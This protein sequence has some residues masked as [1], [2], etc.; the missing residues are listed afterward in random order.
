[1]DLTSIKANWKTT[2]LGIF[3]IMGAIGTAGVA[4]LDSDPTTIVDWKLTAAGIVSGW[5]FI[6]AKDADVTGGS[7]PAT[8]EA[9]AR[10]VPRHRV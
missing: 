10:T 2:A 7:V 1:M 9:A 3:M 6:V 4:L 5:A 8:N